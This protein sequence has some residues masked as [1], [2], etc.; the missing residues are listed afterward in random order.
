[1]NLKIITSTT[2]DVSLGIK[3]ADWIYNFARE[4]KPPVY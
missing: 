3:V 2:R 1:M 4:N